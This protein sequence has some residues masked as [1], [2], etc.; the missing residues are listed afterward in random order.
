MNVFE[1]AE[2][3]KELMVRHRL[4]GWSFRFDKDARAFGSC[5]H[6]RKVITLSASLTELNSD[7]EVKDTIL[8]E[9]AHALVGPDHGH[10]AVWKSKCRQVGARPE[11]TYDSKQVTPVPTKHITQWEYTNWRNAWREQEESW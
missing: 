2:L 10:D 3:A 7:Y 8:H 9:I 6:T 5:N 11:A 4:I 1:A